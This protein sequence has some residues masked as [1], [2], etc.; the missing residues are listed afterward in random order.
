MIFFAALNCWASKT[1]ITVEILPRDT[2]RHGTTRGKLG[3]HVDGARISNAMVEYGC[4]LKASPNIAT[5]S[6]FAS[7]KG[8]VR[9]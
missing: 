8:W 2:Q 9:R 3:L 6:P 1:P 4:E 5:R 7:L